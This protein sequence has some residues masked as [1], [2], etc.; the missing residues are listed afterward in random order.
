VTVGRMQMKCT[1][2]TVF[3]CIGRTCVEVV[4]IRV[5]F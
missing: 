1:D 3:L 2:A 4:Q 5:E